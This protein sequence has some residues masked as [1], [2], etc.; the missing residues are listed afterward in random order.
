MVPE[1]EPVEINNVNYNNEP[2]DEDEDDDDDDGDEFND[3]EEIT[4]EILDSSLTSGNY[5]SLAQW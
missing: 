1:F 3:V 4:D 2:A 5:Y